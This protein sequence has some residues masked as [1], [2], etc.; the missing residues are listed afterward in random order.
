MQENSKV[1]SDILYVCGLLA[2]DGINL[3]RGIKDSLCFKWF[4]N[5]ALTYRDVMAETDMYERFN[6]NNHTLKSYWMLGCCGPFGVIDQALL[7]KVT[8]PILKLDNK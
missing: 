6:I 7:G 4:L 1:E 8:F 5:L 2:C 3:Y